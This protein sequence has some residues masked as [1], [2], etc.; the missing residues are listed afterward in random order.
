ML[1]VRL[2]LKIRKGIVVML[3]ISKYSILYSFFFVCFYRVLPEGLPSN[4]NSKQLLRK[5]WMT[6]SQRP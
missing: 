6:S 2:D 5:I 3:M 1:N 4:A